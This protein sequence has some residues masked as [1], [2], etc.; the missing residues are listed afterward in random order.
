MMTEEINIWAIDD[1]N[2][3]TSLAV[4]VVGKAVTSVVY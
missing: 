3:A 2:T 4:L 1:E